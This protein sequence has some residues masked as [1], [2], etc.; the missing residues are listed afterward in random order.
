MQPGRGMNAASQKHVE[1]LLHG[2]SLA[3]KIRQAPG[4]CCITPGSTPTS[5]LQLAMPIQMI[6]VVTPFHNRFH[7]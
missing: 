7:N 4:V 1:D 6:R 5:P 3:Q 2:F